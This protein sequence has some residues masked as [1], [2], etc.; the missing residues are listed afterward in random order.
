M[1]KLLYILSL[2]VL[3]GFMSCEEEIDPGMAPNTELHGTWSVSEYSLDL[4]THYYGPSHVYTYNTSFGEDSIWVDNIYDSGIK[5][6]A[7]VVSSTSFSATGS[8]DVSGGVA[9]VD[10]TEAQILG[11]SI[12]FRVTLYLADGS[13]YDDYI[14]AGTRTTGWGSDTH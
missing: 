4:Q 1:K 2:I 13:V 9:T 11:D 6:K 10:I 5:V 7:G 14:E 12:I 3:L 8:V